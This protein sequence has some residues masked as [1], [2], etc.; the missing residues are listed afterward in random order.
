MEM[1]SNNNVIHGHMAADSGDKCGDIADVLMSITEDQAQFSDIGGDSDAEDGL[2][3]D[4]QR[5][6]NQSKSVSGKNS[7]MS[8]TS[9]VDS[10]DSDHGSSYHGP[11]SSVDSFEL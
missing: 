10:T 2:V 1:E 8:S 6:T 11:P 4:Q 3:L 7:H 5:S 9:S